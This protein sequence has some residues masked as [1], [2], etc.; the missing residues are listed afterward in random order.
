[1][2]GG[3]E[4]Q[5]ERVGVDPEDGDGRAVDDVQGRV[6]QVGLDEGVAEEADGHDRYDRQHD[7]SPP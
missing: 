4:L 5:A 7:L 1:M 2:A 3:E 6:L